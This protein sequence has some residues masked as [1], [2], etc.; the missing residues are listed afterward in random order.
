MQRSKEK[1]TARRQQNTK[2]INEAKAALGATDIGTLCSLIE[3]LAANND[4]LLKLNA[5][6]E[7]SVADEDFASEFETVMRYEDAARGMLGQLK[8]KEAE[9]LRA[10]RLLATQPAEP[11]R[12]SQHGGGE[13]VHRSAVKLPTLQLQTFNGE[14]RQWRGFWEHFKEAVDENGNLTKGEKFPFL[15]GLLSGAAASSIAGLQATGECYDDVVNILSKRFGDTRQIIQEH[16]AQ[17]RSLPSVTSSD[18]VRGLRKLVDHVQCHVRGLNGLK[19]SSTTYS[20]MMVDILLKALPADIVVGYYKRLANTP[21]WP[22][23]ASDTQNGEPTSVTSPSG[24]PERR[25]L[26]EGHLRSQYSEKEYIIEAIEVPFICNDIV[27]VPVEH[28]FVRAIEETGRP[29]ADKLLLP[30][31]PAVPGIGLLIGAEHLWKFMTGEIKRSQQSA[32]LVALGSVFGWMFRGPISVHTSVDSSA[33]SCVLRVSTVLESTERLVK[34]FWE[35]ESIGI[36]DHTGGPNEEAEAIV[37]QF[38]RNI[39]MKNGRYEVALPW[40]ENSGQLCDNRSQALKRLKSLGKRTQRTQEFGAEYESTMRSYIDMGYAERVTPEEQAI[41]Q[42]YYMPHHAVLRS[43]SRTTK[44]RIVFD[45]SS[46]EQGSSSLNEHLEK[47]PCLLADLVKLLIRFRL[48]QVALTADIAKAFLQISV[49]KE[50]RDSL[51]FLWFNGLPSKEEP[52]PEVE[53]W[54]MKRVPFGTKASPFL[55]N[56]TLQYHLKAV[57][58]PKQR[59]AALLAES[60]YVDDLLLGADTEKVVQPQSVQLHIFCDA[61]QRAYGAC[62]Y[63]R[64]QDSKGS[65]HTELIYAKARVSPLK[66]MTLPRLE[67]MGALIGARIAKFLE[68]CLMMY[69]GR[70]KMIYWTDSS[71]TLHW[72]KGNP[73][74]WNQFVRNRVTKVQICT[75]KDQW[76]HCPGSQNPADRVTRGVTIQSL[77]GD[78][79]WWFGPSWLSETE[80]SWPALNESYVPTPEESSEERKEVKVLQRSKEKRTARRQQ[81]TKLINEA[82]AALGATDIGTLCSLIERLAANNDELLKLNAE[83]E[84]S[85]ADEDFASEFET[86]MRYEDAARG[87]LGQLK[88]KEA[89]LLRAPRLL[90]TQPAEPQ[91]GSQQ[92]GGEAVHRSAVKLP[93]LQLQTFNVSCLYGF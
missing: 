73:L 60:F 22:R 28:N 50:D 49:R 63:L 38:E 56:A 32:D 67:L 4:E 18:D 52:D 16:L 13:A 47:G 76:R 25:R 33:N 44:L 58:E 39:R 90:A 69:A 37:G 3:R 7:D 66:G 6:L 62:A 35:L 71:I 43:D 79:L 26:V 57:E 48:H 11:Q 75:E 92:G 30:G 74:Q 78:R 12:G 36:M 83:L 14:L 15:K 53:E 84:D 85:V 9:L 17:L 42:A 89:E 10:P 59:I 51:R 88:A 41:D 24:A 81:N 70:L 19:V 46:H 23:S 8:A 77:Q 1:R 55:L 64:L 20:A 29:I 40:K 91:R 45:A 93:T 65:V 72:L 27:Q 2:L 61:S 31:M 68:G 5:E 87:M 82:K 21:E 80:E 86:V 54:R 34:G